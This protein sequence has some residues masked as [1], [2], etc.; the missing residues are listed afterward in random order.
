MKRLVQVGQ[1]FG[2]FHVIEY[3]SD[4]CPEEAKKQMKFVKCID[5]VTETVV[6]KRADHLKLIGE[7]W[8]KDCEERKKI[9][10]YKLQHNLD[11]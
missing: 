9:R 4:T 5:M 11:P 8:E 1:T 6:W 7:N 3:N 2:R 10:A